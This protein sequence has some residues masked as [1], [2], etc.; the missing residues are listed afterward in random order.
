MAVLNLQGIIIDMHISP[1]LDD[2]S[3]TYLNVM[4]GE[5]SLGTKQTVPHTELLVSVLTQ[6]PI[7]HVF[8]T[9]I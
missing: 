6:K 7:S 2:V 1:D 8:F 4:V 5:V 3:S 9:Y